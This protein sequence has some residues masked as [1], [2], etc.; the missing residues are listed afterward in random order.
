MN[1]KKVEFKI[2]KYILR[3]ALYFTLRRAATAQ[4]GLKVHIKEL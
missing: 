3:L 1:L 4:K 2:G